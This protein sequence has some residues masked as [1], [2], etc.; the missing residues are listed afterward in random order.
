M[1][2]KIKK[3]ATFTLNLINMFTTPLVFMI[4]W[5]WFVV[6]IGAPH[7]GYL[8]SFGIILLV[9]F[10]IYI[11]SQNN[12]LIYRNNDEAIDFKFQNACG[13][14]AMVIWT[15]VIGAFVHSFI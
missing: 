7:V 4:M 9:D 6:Q 14:T 11:P 1:E 10:A 15:L 2:N 3:V 12:I 8:V 13:G 5:N